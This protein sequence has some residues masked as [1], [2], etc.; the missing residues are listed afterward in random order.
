MRTYARQTKIKAKGK[1]LAVFQPQ[2]ALNAV[3]LTLQLLEK[4]AQHVPAPGLKAAVGA[5]LS[6][7]EMLQVRHA[8]S[9]R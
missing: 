8:G 1:L 6:V 7:I 5:L 9:G 4:T 2:A 3:T